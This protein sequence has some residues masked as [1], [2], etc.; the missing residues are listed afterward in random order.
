M[1]TIDEEKLTVFYFPM[2]ARGQFITDVLDIIGKKYELK[3]IQFKDWEAEKVNTPFGVLPVL[4]VDGKKIGGSVVIARFVA[5][6]FGK[7]KLHQESDP[8]ISALYEGQADM[9]NDILVKL[10]SF[11]F[12]KEE[13]KVAKGEEFV[14]FAKDKLHFLEKS[15]N[16]GGVFQGKDG[17]LTWSEIVI[18]SLLK[19]IKKHYEKHDE[20]L[21]QFPNLIALC[22]EVAKLLPSK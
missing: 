7:S 14:S 20:V 4:D 16:S 5:E 12:A 2:S 13:N 11:V 8:F 21:S 9:C 18:S 6:R 1:A 10:F 19:D 15:I 17:M 22:N 3:T